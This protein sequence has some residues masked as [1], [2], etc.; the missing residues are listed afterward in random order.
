MDSQPTRALLMMVIATCRGRYFASPHSRY[1]GQVMRTETLRGPPGSAPRQYCRLGDG[2]QA[3]VGSRPR[4]LRV[5]ATACLSPIVSGSSFRRRTP[6]EI[7]LPSKPA[8]VG[9]HAYGTLARRHDASAAE[10]QRSRHTGPADRAMAGAM[11]VVKIRYASTV[12]DWR[13]QQQ[14]LVLPESNG[15]MLP[16]KLRM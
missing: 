2:R 4:S 9:S 15:A 10:R 14:A 1:A 12:I 6:K 5:V 11:P 16:R 8:P 3:P 7:H 13:C